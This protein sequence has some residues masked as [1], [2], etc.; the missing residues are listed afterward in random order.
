MKRNLF[1]AQ[2]TL[3]RWA[4]E[5]K[6]DFDK[7][8]ITIKTD[9]RSYRLLEA[10]RFLEVEGGGEDAGGLLG[11]VKTIDK[12]KELGAE[13]CSDS[14]IYRDTAYRVQPGFLAEI[15]VSEEEP[16]LRLETPPAAKHQPQEPPSG[17]GNTAR[18]EENPSDI[19]LLTRFLLKNL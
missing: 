18:P 13:R 7:N 11:K 8:V 2:N 15:L 10:V 12:L 17:A 14:V 19:E 6:I 16:T 9:G 3:D 4:E 1:I 5:G